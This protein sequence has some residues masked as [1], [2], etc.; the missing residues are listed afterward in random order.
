MAIIYGG[1]RRNEEEDGGIE[2]ELKRPRESR[3][4][5]RFQASRNPGVLRVAPMGELLAN[6]STWCGPE[7]DSSSHKPQT[8]THRT[9]YVVQ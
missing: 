4:M 1:E 9:S 6:R 3:G 8:T 5:L 7:K 2:A